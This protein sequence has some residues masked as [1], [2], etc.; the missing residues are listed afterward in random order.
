M[1]NFPRLAPSPTFLQQI[2]NQLGLTAFVNS[3]QDFSNGVN[4]MPQAIA[5]AIPPG[6]LE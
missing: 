2:A 3:F 1:D 6:Y 5:Q 4:N